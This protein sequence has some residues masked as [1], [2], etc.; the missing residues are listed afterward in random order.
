MVPGRY[1]GVLARQAADDWGDLI[2][3]SPLSGSVSLM[4]SVK[5]GLIY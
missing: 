5:G 2:R 1:T 3:H 4:H